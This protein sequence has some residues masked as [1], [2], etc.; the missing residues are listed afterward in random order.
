[1]N[2]L[3]RIKTTDFAVILCC[4]ALL[5]MNFGAIGSRGRERAKETVCLSNLRQWGVIADTYTQNHDGLFWP[6]DPG[7]PCYWWIKY[8][9]DQYKDWKKNKLWFCP[10]ANKPAYDENGEQLPTLTI[11]NAWGIY[12]YDGLGPNGIAGSYA[13]NG[14]VLTPRPLGGGVTTY[15]GG[16]SVEYGWRIPYVTGAANVPV[17]LDALRFDVWPRETEAPPDGFPPWSGNWMARCCI[18]RHN[19]AV[20]CLFMDWS[21]RKVGLKEL[22]KLKWHRGFNTD[23]PWTT[24]GGVQPNDWPEW[25]RDFKDY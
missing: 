23:G 11:F 9:D 10:E 16:V 19:G 20:G 5:L 2:K 13:L 3:G 22:W 7:T 1:M 14:Y 21:A 6:T 15:E 17:F 18:N 4:A 24:A 8:L 25:M 12:K